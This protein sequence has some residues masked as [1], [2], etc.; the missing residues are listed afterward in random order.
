MHSPHQLH[1]AHSG[2]NARQD[3]VSGV[4]IHAWIMLMSMKM[5]YSR[6]KFW[7]T[8]LVYMLSYGS[9]IA[10]IDPSVVFVQEVIIVLRKLL[11][12]ELSIWGCNLDQL[13]LLLARKE[14]R[15]L[16]IWGNLGCMALTQITY[17]HHG[18]LVHKSM[19]AP[20][21]HISRLHRNLYS[22]K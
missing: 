7:Y 9:W 22:V 5:Q 15:Q 20:D 12:G 17:T 10:I 21:M 8:F 14:F 13:Y 16:K 4:W 11:A 2:E 18:L 3:V 19:S 1:V 6:T